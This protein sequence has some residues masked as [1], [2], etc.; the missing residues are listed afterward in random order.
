MSPETLRRPALLAEAL[1]A[2]EEYLPAMEAYRQALES[3]LPRSHNGRRRLALGLGE[4]AHKL[5]QI[6]TAIAA[7]QD[8]S[9]ADPTGRAHPTQPS[10]AYDAAGLS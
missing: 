1:A 7:L 6:E 3:D 8:A 4:V 10:E 2:N 5:G 9:Q